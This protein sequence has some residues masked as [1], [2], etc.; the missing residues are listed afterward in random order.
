MTLYDINI[1]NRGSTRNPDQKYIKNINKALVRAGANPAEIKDLIKGPE[2]KLLDKIFR[3][4]DEN[5]KPSKEN[6]L[7]KIGDTPLSLEITKEA[8]NLG[9]KIVKSSSLS[10]S[11][12]QSSSLPHI[13]KEP[14]LR[15]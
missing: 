12:S 2:K 8:K 5:S 4:I 14:R 7:P 11:S 13:P 10:S 9:K 6:K 3:G 15:S 1:N